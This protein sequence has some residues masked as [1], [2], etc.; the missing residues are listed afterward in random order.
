[1]E[2]L[3]TVIFGLIIE[4]VCLAFVDPTLLIPTTLAGK[5][6]ASFRVSVK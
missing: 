2:F 6:W 1:M 3:T 5:S 4:K